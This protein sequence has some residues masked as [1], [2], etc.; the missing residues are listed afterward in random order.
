MSTYA[1]LNYKDRDRTVEVTARG[2][3]QEWGA[4]PNKE[5]TVQSWAVLKAK[6]DESLGLN[7]DKAEE[8]VPESTLTDLDDKAYKVYLAAMEPDQGPV[9]WREMNPTSRHHWRLLAVDRML[10]DERDAVEADR[11]QAKAREQAKVE[12]LAQ[13]LRAARFRTAT[14]WSSVGEENRNVWRRVARTALEEAGK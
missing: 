1:H 14:P 5:E 11:R 8:A 10:R 13:K 4:H 6:I 3:G 12:A 9:P 7:D 2:P